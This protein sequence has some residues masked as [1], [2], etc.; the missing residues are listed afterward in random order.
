MVT[1]TIVL[2]VIQLLVTLIQLI[3]WTVAKG[4]YCSPSGL[5]WEW[6]RDVDMGMNL[7]LL[8]HMVTVIAPF[9]IFYN[10]FY[11][12]PKELNYFEEEM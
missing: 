10:I 8:F 4:V 2:A 5:Y 6:D 9:Q 12:I 3:S 1:L 11:T 7:F